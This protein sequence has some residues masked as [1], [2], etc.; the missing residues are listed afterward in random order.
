MM[1]ERRER[2][3]QRRETERILVKEVVKE[4]KKDIYVV[5]KEVNPKE[6]KVKKKE[7]GGHGDGEKRK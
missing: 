6:T 7:N 5:M 2:K 3:N 1:G 4:R